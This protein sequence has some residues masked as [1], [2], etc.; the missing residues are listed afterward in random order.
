MTNIQKSSDLDK[1]TPEELGKLFPIT[2]E[3]YNPEWKTLFQKEKQILIDLLGPNLLRIAHIGST[4]IPTI[5]SKPIIDILLEIP[6]TKIARE[7]TIHSMK[8]RGYHC[9]ERSDRTPPHMMFLKGYTPDGYVSPVYH[10]HVADQLNSGIWDR[11]Y[12][13]DFLIENESIAKEYEALKL[14]LAQKA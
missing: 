6:S 4:A 7:E 2:L 14:E 1:L 10:I 9:V 12:F 13:R 8:M 3:E 11:L 5:Q